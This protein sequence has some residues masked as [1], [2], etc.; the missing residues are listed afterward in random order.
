MIGTSAANI[1]ADS[2]GNLTLK[3]SLVSTAAGQA[4][5]AAA[6]E[7]KLEAGTTVEGMHTLP[8]FTA[9][10]N[11]PREI[12]AAGFAVSGD[13]LFA[14]TPKDVRLLKVFPDDREGR[15]FDFAAASGDYKDKTFTV[16]DGT[17]SVPEKIVAEESYTLVL[18]IR[19]YGDF[20][21]DKIDNGSVTDPVALLQT[22]APGGESNPGESSS[23]S[24]GGCSAGYGLLALLAIV[25]AALRRKKN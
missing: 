16:L 7:G 18:F 6:K 14:E 1:T 13:A 9:A 24:G 25:P 10:G 8:I 2:K 22:K 5:A 11:E 21:L 3:N 12:I 20:D 17:N 19:D 23:S 4:I 15:L